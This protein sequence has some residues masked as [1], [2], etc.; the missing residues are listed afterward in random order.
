MTRMT[1][2]LHLPSPDR[3]NML[4]TPRATIAMPTA[5]FIILTKV[6][7]PHMPQH[8]FVGSSVAAAAA[9]YAIFF[10]VYLT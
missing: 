7:V 9:G 8:S 2:I 10:V 5:A 4:K 3:P 6:S 1:I